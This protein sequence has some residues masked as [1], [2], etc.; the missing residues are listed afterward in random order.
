MSLKNWL[1][2]IVLSIVWGGSFYF[3]EN[4][5]EHFTFEQIVFFRVF[6][7]TLFILAV[8]IV[9]KIKIVLSLKLWMIFLVMSCLNNVIP[10]LAITYA[11]ETITASLASLFNATTP[12]FTAIL[13]NFLTKDEKLTWLKSIGI[14]VG[15]VGMIILL[16]PDAF[17]TLESA[18]FFAIAGAISYACA[19]VYGKRL[20]GYDPMLSVFGMLSCSSVIIY[21]LFSSSI[22]EVD[23]S[24]LY[25]W[26]DLIWLA[27]FSTTIAYIIYFKLLFSIGAVKLLLVTYL[28]PISASALG[29]FLLNEEFTSSMILGSGFIF[30]SL[31]L[32]NKDKNDI[33]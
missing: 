26:Q 3:V 19:G 10:F 23:V 1:L 9:K 6:F 11:Q 22:N 18:S 4:S 5:F 13:A 8:L 24:S 33:T 14:L 20:K 15:F 12:V 7:A 28:I 2:L 27:L 21:V 30:V 31:W 29:V 25:A 16:Q 17:S 32:I